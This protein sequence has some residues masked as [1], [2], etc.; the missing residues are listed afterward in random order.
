MSCKNKGTPACNGLCCDGSP[1][2]T[3]Y[4]PDE[5]NEVKFEPT[6]HT[7]L[8]SSSY[9]YTGNY[10]MHKL[11]CGYC[12]IMNRPCVNGNTNWELTFKSNTN[13]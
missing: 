1:L 2:K 10:C 4:Q 13:E 9:Y 6:T 11:P 5:V 12:A 7:T 3:C 8:S